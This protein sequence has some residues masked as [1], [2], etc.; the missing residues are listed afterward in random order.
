M[1]KH[2][3]IYRM[4]IV[5]TGMRQTQLMMGMPFA[6]VLQSKFMDK[7]ATHHFKIVK[8]LIEESGLMVS[9]VARTNGVQHHGNA[10]RSPIAKQLPA[11]LDMRIVQCRFH[12]L[13]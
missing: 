13:S 1:A 8:I 11:R 6:N 2:I 3:V 4:G 10:C 7:D 9:I 5:A 12:A